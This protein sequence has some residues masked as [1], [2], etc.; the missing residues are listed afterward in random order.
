MAAFA[1]QR[2]L[3]DLQRVGFDHGETTGRGVR[4]VLQQRQ[5]ARVL[6]DGDHA[7]RVAFDQRARK[8]A[9]ARTDLD[10]RFAVEGAGEAHDLARDIQVEQEM[11]TEPLLREQAVLGQ[12]F[13][14]RR[15]IVD[16]HATDARRCA[17]SAP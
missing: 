6:L 1:G 17:I 3:V 14:K 2:A 7:T 16:V 8:A 13:A 12:G 4:E 15:Q 10:H 11:L 5:K 9:R